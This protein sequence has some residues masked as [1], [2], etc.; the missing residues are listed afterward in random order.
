MSAG[1]RFSVI[2]P[3][4]RRPEFLERCLAGLTAQTLAPLEV[5]V[6]HSLNDDDTRE[7]LLRHPG[8]TQVT[9][10][11][12]SNADGMTAGALRARGEIICLID[13][14]AVPRPDWLELLAEH[15][16]TPGVGAVG[17]RDEQPG[18]PPR[19]GAVVGR[20]GTWGRMVGNHHVGAGSARAV[21]VLKGVNMAFRRDVMALPLDLRGAATQDHFEV[22]MSLWVARQGRRVVYDPAVVV[23]HFVAPRV[24]GSQRFS[25]DHDLAR[26]SAFNL[27]LS[28]LSLRPG[29]TMR[30]ALYGL[31][32]G[33]R[34]CPGLLRGAVAALQRD[35]SVYLKLWPSLL[36][37]T[38]ALSRIARRRPLRMR[39]VD[40]ASPEEGGSAVRPADQP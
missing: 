3:T 22:S 34:G 12:A 28:M 38:D 31:A 13:D 21:D 1:P 9:I 15:F 40:S 37:Q 20:I 26:A 27:V 5:L 24:D 7:L 39:P 32:I 36:G 8:V 17:G 6:V 30:R 19:P 10:P 2:V 25:A 11:T 18:T 16:A 29:L 33:D 14:D 23:D 35:P 4:N